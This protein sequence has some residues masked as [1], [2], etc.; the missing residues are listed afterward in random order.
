MQLHKAK[1]SVWFKIYATTLALV[2]FLLVASG[3]I[4]GLQVKSL[5]KL[6]IGSSAIGAAAF[7]GFVLAG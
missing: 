4:M 3:V 2:L 6:T 5:R 7:V 1:G